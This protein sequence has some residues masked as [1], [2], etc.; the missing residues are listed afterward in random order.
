MS[1]GLDGRRVAV[2]WNLHRHRFSVVALDGAEK[3]RVVAH[4][5]AIDL[6]DATFAVGAAGRD[7]VRATGA[8]NVHARI[9]GVARPATTDC[10]VPVT[11]NPY[12]HDT[13]VCRTDLTPVT[14]AKAVTLTSA[15]N[16]PTILASGCTP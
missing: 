6:A 15:E 10:T 11:Y 4:V 8:K 1:T 5:E 16:R 13:F 2:Y 9:R 14:A 3:G 12:L 7:K